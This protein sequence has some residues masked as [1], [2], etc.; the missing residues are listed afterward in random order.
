MPPLFHRKAYMRFVDCHVCTNPMLGL[1]VWDLV[2]DLGR[3]MLAP[4]P[5]GRKTWMHQSFHM[6]SPFHRKAGMHSVDCHV[7]TKMVGLEV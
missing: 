1:V 2:Q 6:P 7:C 3:R 4:C 5:S